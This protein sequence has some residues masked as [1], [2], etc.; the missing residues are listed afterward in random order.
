MIS[1]SVCSQSQ[2]FPEDLKIVIGN[3]EGSITYLDYQTNE[4]FTMPANLKVEQGKNKYKLVLKNIYPNEPKANTKNKIKIAKNGLLLNK[5]TVT[6]REES[7]NGQIEIKTEHK[8]KDNNENALIR[9]TYVIGKNLFII[10]KEVQFNEVNEW[11]KR[12]EFNYV[13]KQ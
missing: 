8:G 13:R 3:W 12:S 7:E 6:S 10:R 11:I 1:V 2:I 5:H 4:P 9:Y